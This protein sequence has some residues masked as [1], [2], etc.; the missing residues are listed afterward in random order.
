MSNIELVFSI[1]ESLA[2]VFRLFKT[3]LAKVRI[4]PAAEPVLLIPL[5]LAVSD[6]NNFVGCH[7]NGL[8]EVLAKNE[9]DKIL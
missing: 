6:H 5:R 3:L 1:L 7:F 2:S 9:R 4:E 8:E